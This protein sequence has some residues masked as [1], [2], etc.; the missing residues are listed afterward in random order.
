M[1]NPA[2]QGDLVEIATSAI[3]AAELD[4]LREQ[5]AKLKMTAI[6]KIAI[7]ALARLK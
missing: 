3:Y 1:T 4:R 2:D 6:K 5:V 7:S